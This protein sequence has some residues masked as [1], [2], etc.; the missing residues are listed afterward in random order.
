MKALM[1]LAVAAATLAAA[2][3]SAH[4]AQFL[5]IDGASGAFGRTDIT[6]EGGDVAPC[7]FTTT[8]TFDAPIG[9]DFAGID[10]SS[11][12]ANDDP[13]T[14]S[15]LDLG[16]VTFNGVAFNPGVTGRLEYRNIFAALLPT[17]NEIVVNGTTAGHAAF[18]GTLAFA[19]SA[20]IPEPGTWA[21]LLAG[22]G[23]VGYS[24]RRRRKL[25]K[26]VLA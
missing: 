14:P 11:V 4:A 8:F 6:C 26:S 10:V 20:A 1:K 21:M 25:A 24:L 9:F 18:A 7:A 16:L 2:A 22:F 17:D 12:A 5:T 15:N 13:A 19:P 23:I 3:S